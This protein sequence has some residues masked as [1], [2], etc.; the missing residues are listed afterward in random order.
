MSNATRFAATDALA[1]TVTPAAP[2]PLQPGHDSGTV[3]GP[4]IGYLDNLYKE[5]GNERG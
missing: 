5:H 2:A 1:F 3:I 4:A